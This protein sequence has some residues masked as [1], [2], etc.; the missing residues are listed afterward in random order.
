MALRKS[1]PVKLCFSKS[2]IKNIVFHSPC[3]LVVIICWPVSNNNEFH[4]FVTTKWCYSQFQGLKTNFFSNA[5][6]SSQFLV[7]SFR[8]FG[9]CSSC[10]IWLRQ[11]PFLMHS[12]LLIMFPSVFSTSSI[13]DHLCRSTAPNFNQSSILKTLHSS[14][15]MKVKLNINSRIQ[16]IE[17]KDGQHKRNLNFLRNYSIAQTYICQRLRSVNEDPVDI[18]VGRRHKIYNTWNKIQF[19]TKVTIARLYSSARI[20]FLPNW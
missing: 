8:S 18:I 19:S 20:I 16:M 4:T 7:P 1:P 12:P 2:F 14:K 9:S 3:S 17:F 13:Y 11:D 6:S 5:S 10:F 15:V